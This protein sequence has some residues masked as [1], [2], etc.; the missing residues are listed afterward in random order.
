MVCL[1]ANDSEKSTQKI[2]TG[3]SALAPAQA[4]S[5]HLHDSFIFFC[6]GVNEE[7]THGDIGTETAFAG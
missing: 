1:H 3:N 7:G 6:G 2:W 4:N 5:L